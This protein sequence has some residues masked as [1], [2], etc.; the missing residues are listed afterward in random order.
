[1]VEYPKAVTSGKAFLFLAW[2]EKDEGGEPEPT[3]TGS[4][5]KEGPS[6]QGLSYTW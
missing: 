4:L 3:E 1:M 2:K 5:G 6:T